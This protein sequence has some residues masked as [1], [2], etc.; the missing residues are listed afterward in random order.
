MKI[1]T[2][3]KIQLKVC[4]SCNLFLLIY[5]YYY[6]NNFL[7]SNEYCEFCVNKLSRS[8]NANLLE[9]RKDS[10]RSFLKII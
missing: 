1:N 8:V 9:D 10:F 2:V 5:T 7:V 3:H 4:I 6:F